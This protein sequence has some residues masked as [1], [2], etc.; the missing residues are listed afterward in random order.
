MELTLIHN[1]MTALKYL[2]SILLITTT[3]SKGMSQVKKTTV[4]AQ[5][6]E[7]YN[8]IMDY[9][10]SKGLKVIPLSNALTTVAQTH[11]L[12]LNN[13]N[14]DMETRCNAHS[15]SNKGKWTSCCY[16]PDHK[17]A[18]CMWNKPK[19]LTT[20]PGIGY[21]ISVGGSKYLSFVMTPEYAINS[22]KNSKW[23]NEV[24]IDKGMW[25][26]KEWNAIGIGIYKGFA[27]VWFGE[28]KDPEGAPKKTNK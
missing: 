12:D 27:T 18:D 23:H 19:E 13:N 9:R 20:Y 5:Q 16:T 24:M 1:T 7:L 14:P 17:Q 21:E 25:V 11:C 15:W 2:L 8:L 10:K 22:W 4:N 28:E 26:N 6:M 3:L